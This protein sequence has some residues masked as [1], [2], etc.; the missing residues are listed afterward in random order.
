MGGCLSNKKDEHDRL[1][2]NNNMNKYLFKYSVI[3]TKS[4]L[5]FEKNDRINILLCEND[6]ILQNNKMTYPIIYNNIIGWSNYG[7]YYWNLSFM[8]NGSK[9]QYLLFGVP[10]SKNISEK[11][12]QITKK[13]KLDYKDL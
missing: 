8:Y 6:L 13:I 11:L 9:K 12:L 5:K 3:I 2:M 1:V 10:D 7:Y 4:F